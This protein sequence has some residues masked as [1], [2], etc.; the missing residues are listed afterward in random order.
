M[1]PH[2]TDTA[3]LVFGLLFLGIAGWWLL[4]QITDFSLS[5]EVMAWLGAGVLVTVGGLGIA[6]AIRSGRD[7]EH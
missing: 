2:R 1:R 3:S 4:A 5:L 7:S 6:A